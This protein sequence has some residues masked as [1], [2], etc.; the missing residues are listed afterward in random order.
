MNLLTYLLAIVI[1]TALVGYLGKRCA[2]RGV[3]ELYWATHRV[4][5]ATFLMF[6]LIAVNYVMATTALNRILGNEQYKVDARRDPFGWVFLGN[7]SLYVAP[8]LAIVMVVFSIVASGVLVRSVKVLLRLVA[9]AG[10]RPA[11]REWLPAALWVAPMGAVVAFDAS[12]MALRLAMM[13]FPDRL[14]GDLASL[15]AV[16]RMGDLGTAAGSLL[17]FA[18]LAYPA[19]ILAAERNFSHAWEH[20]NRLSLGAALPDRN[21]EPAATEEPPRRRQMPPPHPGPAANDP[22]QDVIRP[23]PPAHH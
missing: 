15:P 7:H 6:L 22:F 18:V 11:L 5:A 3:G 19:I 4:F 13:L 9:P 12:L 14:E 16:W 21:T 17:F 2:Q 20:F 1:A 10:E 23:I 8:L